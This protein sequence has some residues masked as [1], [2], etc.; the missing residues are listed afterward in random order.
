MTGKRQVLRNLN[1]NWAGIFGDTIVSFLLCPYLLKH[2]GAE[3]YGA[4]I[5][6]GS[7]TG[8][9]GLLDLGIRGS[10]GRY[11]A[12]YRAKNDPVAAGEIVSTALLLLSL[13][14]VLGAAGVSFA[15]LW[16]D[17]LLAGEF[18]PEELPSL[19]WAVVLSAATLALQLPLNVA[20]GVL[21][22]CQR[23]DRLNAVRIPSDLARGALSALVVAYDGG[24]VA[25]SAVAL[26]LT[27]AGG[28]A[29]LRLARQS[30]PEISW[31]PRRIARP[32]LREVCS[33]G[34]WS[35]LRSITTMIP[36]RV[37][38]LL[39]GGILGVSVVT[40][41]SIAARLIAASSA[42][43]VAATGVVTPIATA[44]HAAGDRERERQLLLEGGKYSL[45]AASLFLALFTLLGRPLLHLWVGPEMDAAY[46]I[47]IVFAGGRWLSMSQV[48]TRG[49]ITAQAK[50]RTLA[51]SSIVQGVLTLLLGLALIQP[52]GAVGMAIAVAIGDGLCEGLFSLIYGCRVVGVSLRDYLWT[53]AS[54]AARS[55][56]VPCA[57]LAAAL[58][59]RPVETWL[60][61]IAYGTTFATASI[62]GTVWA[63]EG[64]VGPLLAKFRAARSEKR[65]CAT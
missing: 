46:W 39:V 33:F 12:Y 2:L 34:I 51:L 37:T 26:G 27:L 10:V 42:I 57:L 16:A 45:A 58:Q 14:G 65:S 44:L 3:H 13:A 4:W 35:T 15:G 38:P 50:H 11:V 49:I 20:D 60:D 40:P 9:F 6:L 43:L 17:W 28:L 30:A 7:L 32:R 41:M 24:L 21:W 1:W 59:W 61:L 63:N 25:L 52:W 19:R 53:V 31:H 62:V 8:Y 54:A 36:A 18:A 48:V 64:A 56:L 55:V 29:K 47:L 23:F 22:G 5:M